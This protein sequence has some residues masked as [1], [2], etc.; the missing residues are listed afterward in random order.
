[1]SGLQ[2][3]LDAFKQKYQTSIFDPQVFL[4]YDKLRKTFSK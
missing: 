3:F 1:M 2:V 4:Q